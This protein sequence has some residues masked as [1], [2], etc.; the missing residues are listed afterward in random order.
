MKALQHPR[1]DWVVQHDSGVTRPGVFDSEE[2][3]NQSMYL[4]AQ[5]LQSIYVPLRSGGSPLTMDQIKAAFPQPQP[6]T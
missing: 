4:T 5:K 1:G 3:A 2:T 6:T